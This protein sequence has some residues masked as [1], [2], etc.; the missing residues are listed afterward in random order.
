MTINTPTIKIKVD[1]SY[2][3]DDQQSG[4][5]EAYLVAV[6]C[7]KSRPLLFTVHLANGAVYSG[8]PITAI[9]ASDS[10]NT[11]TTTL[12]MLQPWS[13][14]EAPVSVI[15]YAHLKDYIVEI[16]SINMKGI[17]QFTVDYHGEGLAQ[18]P[19]QYKTHNIIMLENGN[20]AAMPN[21]MCVFKDDY[22]TED[23]NINLKRTTKY[24]RSK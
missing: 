8:L 6:R 7:I 2:V 5:M 21:N 20:Y 12:D 18:D 17:Y 24:Y 22:F 9:Y 13:C 15:Q 1:L 19:E 10:T 16:P 11:T 3:T 23:L 4:L 14:L